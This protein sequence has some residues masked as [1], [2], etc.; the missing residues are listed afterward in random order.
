MQPATSG[1]RDG[2]QEAGVAEHVE[3]E[4]TPNVVWLLKT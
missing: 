1:E 4:S 3:Q 2:W